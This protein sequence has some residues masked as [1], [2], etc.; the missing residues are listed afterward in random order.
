MNIYEYAKR[1]GL[2]MSECGRRGGKKAGHRRRIKAKQ[3]RALESLQRTGGDWW[4]R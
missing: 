2:T 4:N 3:I 1:N